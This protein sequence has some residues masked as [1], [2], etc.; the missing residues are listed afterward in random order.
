VE[1]ADAR[2]KNAGECI[3]AVMPL[4]IARGDVA[5]TRTNHGLLEKA[6]MDLEIALRNVEYLIKENALE[7]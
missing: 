1:K 5:L 7:E 2:L 4:Q 3:G 6:R